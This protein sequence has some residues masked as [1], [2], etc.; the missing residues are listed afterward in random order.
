MRTS[1]QRWLLVLASAFAGIFSV[2]MTTPS[3]ALFPSDASAGPDSSA[4]PNSQPTPKATKTSDPSAQPAP[5]KT[6]STPKKTKTAK[7]Q[8]T[9]TEA[10]PSAVAG[11]MKD[12][13]YTGGSF[14]AGSYGTVKVK[15]TVAGGQIT[16]VETP[17]LPSRDRES[18]RINDQAGPYLRE[19]ALA[20]QSVNIA[21]VGGASYTTSAF[22]KSL[23]DAINKSKK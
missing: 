20:A 18:Q 23:Q 11:D 2:L 16:K 10:A 7:P 6:Q 5:T 21:G 15:I 1:V 14:S 8:A 13:T 22:K 9:K 12:G 4:G 3:S 19:Q 17:S